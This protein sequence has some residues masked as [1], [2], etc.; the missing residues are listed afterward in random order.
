M[1]K[2]FQSTMRTDLVDGIEQILQR[3]VTAFMSDNHIDRDIAVEVFI[4]ASNGTRDDG[5]C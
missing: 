3:K 4:L 1:R 2:A 5:A